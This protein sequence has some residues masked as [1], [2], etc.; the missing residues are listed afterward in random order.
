MDLVLGLDLGT[1]YFKGGLFD[2]GGRLRGLGRVPVPSVS[3]GVRR[4]L[5][6]DAFWSALEQVLAAALREAGARAGDIRGI[7]CSSQA[8]SF[9]L[10]D[11][12]GAPLTP[13]ILWPDRRADPAPAAVRDL[14]AR[15]DFTRTTGLGAT[16]PEMALA[17]I[18]GI[19][20]RAPGLWRKTAR[21][22]T[23][24]EYLAGELTGRP[25]G[26][27]GTSALL[28]LWDLQAHAWW[29][30]GLKQVGLAPEW[31]STP[32]PP[33]APA[34]E[35]AGAGAARLGLDP[36]ARWTAG[37]LDHHMAA[38]GC[39]A[40]TAGSCC[41]SLGTVLVCIR[42]LAA[43]T[44]RAGCFMG[45]GVSAGSFTQLAFDPNGAI[46]L[47]SYRA[48]C[49]PTL[50]DPELERL[51]AAV[52]DDCDGL[53]ALPF[54]PSRDWRDGFLHRTSAH[55][56]GHCARAIMSSVA[57]SLAG[58][59]GKLYG[60]ERPARILAAGGG[61]RS[62]LWMEIFRRR[63]GMNLIPARHPE[64]ACRGAAMSAAVAAGWFAGLPEAVGAWGAGAG[65]GSPVP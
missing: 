59:V 15:D 21:I 13:M 9:L 6:L 19:R 51:A 58:L 61:T 49:A 37:S 26:D 55:G 24:S 5:P 2:R 48:A 20:E 1:S 17:K 62:A 47:E 22:R 52:P 56:P 30:E 7:S 53:V 29:R 39:G 63:L 32:L 50:T 43:F 33:G 31:F 23:I 64:A 27:E 8:N 25:L 45:P 38:I 12:A 10:Q 57:D 4:E 42:E 14:W 41:V 44:P 16:S 35:L 3:D 36:R 65:P 34:G 18:V 54:S 11:S 40:G 28:G 60:A 46:A